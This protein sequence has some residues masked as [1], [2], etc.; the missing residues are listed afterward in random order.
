MCFSILCFSAIKIHISE[1]KISSML[2]CFSQLV[3]YIFDI[4][5]KDTQSGARIKA[6]YPKIDTDVTETLSS[7]WL[8]TNTTAQQVIKYIETTGTDI[9][10]WRGGANRTYEYLDAGETVYEMDGGYCLTNNLTEPYTLSSNFG[11]VTSIYSTTSKLY[12]LLYIE[13]VTSYKWVP[14]DNEIA[15]G[16]EV[17]TGDEKLWIEEKNEAEDELIN[18]E[19]DLDSMYPINSIYTSKSAKNPGEQLGGVWELVRNYMGGELI[20]FGTSYNKNA[21]D[22]HLIG[23]TYKGWSDIFSSSNQNVSI[24]NYTTNTVLEF[25]SGTFKVNTRGLVGLVEAEIILSGNK[26]SDC[27]AI[28]FSD[29]KN[30]IPSG[31]S[32]ISNG[33]ALMSIGMPGT[34]NYGGT[35]NKYYFQAT[36]GPS[37]DVSFYINPSMVAYP[38]AGEFFPGNGGVKCSLSVKVYTTKET[39]YVW[40]R[41]G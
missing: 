36:G 3:Q 39:R 15:V 5:L 37:S 38:S 34:N 13:A 23:G 28:W 29:N 27:Y 24:T 9:E 8:D 20:A 17:P 14:I 32:Q 22:Y 12:T 33:R 18:I 11:T 30:A 40:K 16:D 10:Y 19:V 35:S 1:Q 31:A 4:Y 21:A 2:E 41:T 26:N 25:D 7:Y 6:N